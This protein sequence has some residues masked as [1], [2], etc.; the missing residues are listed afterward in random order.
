MLLQISCKIPLP[1]ISMEPT[2]AIL[3]CEPNE[4]MAPIHD[5]MPDSPPPDCDRYCKPVHR[6][7][8]HSD[9]STFRVRQFRRMDVPDC[10]DPGLLHPFFRYL[11]TGLPSLFTAIEEQLGLKLQR[12]KAGTDVF[13]IDRVG[14]PSQN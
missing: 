9:Q 13:M 5:R 2:F 1:N 4:L 11:A 3:T 10:L 12:T 7:I 8:S 14:Q 6:D